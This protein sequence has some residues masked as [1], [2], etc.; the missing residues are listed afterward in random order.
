MQAPHLENLLSH[1]NDLIHG[2]IIAH[3]THLP[4]IYIY[5]FSYEIQ[6]KDIQ[7]SQREAKTVLYLPIPFVLNILLSKKELS[8]QVMNS[9]NLTILNRQ[10]LKERIISFELSLI[11][12]IN[13]INSRQA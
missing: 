12:G 8:A 13:D 6:R 7:I 3:L 10:I 5:S 11:V 4:S 2:K 9:G 1:C